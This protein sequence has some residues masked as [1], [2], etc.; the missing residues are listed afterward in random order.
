[1]SLGGVGAYLNNGARAVGNGNGG[2][3]VSV[4]GLVVDHEAGRARAVGSQGRDNARG[5]SSGHIGL[6]DSN[7]SEGKDSS[8][9]EHID[10]VE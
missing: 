5:G 4:D 7:S 3:V 1:M 9:G 8:L 6:S 10:G 2:G